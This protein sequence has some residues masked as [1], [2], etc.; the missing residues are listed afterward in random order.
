MLEQ[1]KDLIKAFLL[2]TFDVRE[3]EY[4]RVLL[5]QLN[6]FLL[7]F[8]LLVIK[9]V[10]NAQFLSMMGVDQL[11]LMF[12]MVAISAMGVS[13]IYSRA[14][15]SRSL[16]RISNSTLLISVILL[17][18][19]GILLKLSISPALVLYV[20]YVIVAIFAVLSTSQFW[21]M[22]NLAFDAREAKRLFS[23]IGA[24]PIAGGVAGGYMT[25]I[26]A[27]YIEG[28]NLIFFGAG[29][30]CVCIYLNNV[31]WTRHIPKLTRFQRKKR[32]KD[33][34]DHPIWLIRQSKHLT[35]L[36]LIIGIGVIVSKLI[37][38][39]FSSVAVQSFDDPDELTS[40]FGFWLSTFNV[41]SLLIQLFLTRR[42]VGTYGVGTSLFALPGGI[43]LGSSL[44]LFA[45]VLWAGIFTRLWEV[46]VKQSV[47]KSATEL[48]ALPIPSGIKSQTK[49]FIDVFVD[50]AATGLAGLML[51]FLINGLDLS[52][53]AVSILTIFILIIWIWVALKVRQEY[54]NSFKSKL[55]QIDK[56]NVQPD[57]S[58]ISVFNGLKRALETGTEQQILYVLDKV[59]EIPDKRLFDNVSQFLVHQSPIVRARALQ[60]I[61]YLEKTV[62]P[63]V[64]EGLLSDPDQEVRYKAFAQ[65]LRQTKE[66]RINLIHNYLTHSDPTISG[67]ALVGLAEEAR[68]NEEMKRLLKVEQRIHEKIDY[69]G[70]SEN[71]EEKF[72]YKV[73]ILRAAGH[74]NIPAFYPI[75]RSFMDDKEVR[76][77][78]EAI[79]AAGFTMNVTFIE[80]LAEFLVPRETRKNA[81]LALLNYGVGILPELD[82]VVRNATTRAEVTHMI[83]GVLERI[84]AYASVKVLLSFLNT[85]DVMLRLEALRSL[86]ALQRDFP[87]LRINKKDILGHVI[88]E[89]NVYK[90][91]LG[92]FYKQRQLLPVH[93]SPQIK[94][95][96][97]QLTSL[98]ERRLDGT[99]ERIFRL[100]GLRYP[101]DDIISA[102][103]GI[104][105]VNEHVRLNS[106]EYLDNLLEPTLKK[107]LLPIAESAMLDVLSKDIIDH[108]K[109]TVPDEKKCLVMLLDG[110]DA[111]L[112]L[113]VF[114]LIEAVGSVEYKEM[115]RPFLNSHHEKIREQAAKIL[116]Q[117]AK[118]S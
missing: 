117:Q 107:A 110:R 92:V 8:T 89:C 47:N 105:S 16:R 41:V 30:L 79:L 84:D 91:I 58:N 108:L 73:M 18:F 52:V 78:N 54:L 82:R 45:P 1:S 116:G 113:A 33:F 64:L 55:A 14:L 21:I 111:K 60:S 62:D 76:V 68:N 106:V 90:N 71:P 6:I 9:P 23:F 49:S 85:N 96:R 72:L 65:L 70:L 80:R 103:E 48:L 35:Y 28:T 26:M 27:N 59:R 114:K 42:I 10:V 24:G 98:L 57:Y 39:Q 3:G 74:A 94:E 40:F 118:T 104:R 112:K 100:I 93:E 63:Q 67:A 44:L 7:I 43:L 5:M 69:I 29:L 4:Q 46:S 97:T 15:G 88:D 31:I 50:L 37:E 13:M 20:L 32:M 86:N 51:I 102:Y 115:V 38:F 25:S 99:L 75:I 53:R 12:L 22:A 17:T 87:H 36:A 66:Q 81:Q 83:P 109:V 11:P 56:K 101:P 2:R 61:Y 19:F 77:I 34:G 95:A